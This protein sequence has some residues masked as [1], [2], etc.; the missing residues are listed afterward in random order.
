VRI[1]LDEDLAEEWDP[2]EDEW[3]EGEE[4]WDET[5]EPE[6][7]PTWSLPLPRTRSNKGKTLAP[8]SW[9]K[10]LASLNETASPYGVQRAEA[11]PTGREINY[12]IDVPS[13]Q[14]GQGLG[15][16][17]SV[18]ERKRDGEWSKPRAQRIWLPQIAGLPDPDDRHILSTLAGAREQN[19][20]YGVYSY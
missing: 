18:R 6:P 19:G 20:Y 13:S 8:P 7:R 12:G 16:E 2:V 5:E 17:V 10:Q 14:T 11:W 9:K 3:G 4:E 1:E 15:L